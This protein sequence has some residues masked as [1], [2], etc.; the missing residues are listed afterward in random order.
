S[1]PVQEV[2]R[3]NSQARPGPPAGQT[4]EDVEAAL[5][6]LRRDGLLVENGEPFRAT[7]T[8]FV[9]TVTYV[10]LL[11]PLDPVG[12]FVSHFGRCSRTTTRWPTPI[13]AATHPARPRRIQPRPET[14]P[15]QGT[16]PFRRLVG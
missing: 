8:L 10:R 12:P 11:R 16:Y 13:P 6:T 7:R 5:S 2:G 4:G 15:P 14:P 9:L 1:F 3:G